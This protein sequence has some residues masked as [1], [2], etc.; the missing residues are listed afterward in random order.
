MWSDHAFKEAVAAVTA[1]PDVPRDEDKLRLYGLY[2]QATV[3]PAPKRYPGSVLNVVEFEKY[4]AWSAVRP[5]SINGAR[6]EY[7]ALVKELQA[8]AQSGAPRFML[9]ERVEY[10]DD[11]TVD[12][13][14][15]TVHSVNPLKVKPDGWDSS[16]TFDEV[17][18][19]DPNAPS[20]RVLVGLVFLFKLLQF[21]DRGITSGSPTEFNAFIERTTGAVEQQAVLFASISSA[22]TVGNLAGCVGA[23]G[24]HRAGYTGHRL[25]R[26]GMTL[27]LVG[28]V[29]SS[30]CSALGSAPLVFY[31]FC[32]ARLLV[33][34]GAGAVVV[35]WPPYIE[36]IAMPTER[37]M[38]MTLVEM[39]T[40]L[41]AAT[42]YLYSA[43]MTRACGWGAAYFGVAFLGAVAIVAPMCVFNEPYPYT[44]ARR[45]GE[46][47]AVRHQQEIH[48]IKDP[49]FLEWLEGLPTLH[50]LLC[51]TSR[52]HKVQRKSMD[53]PIE[54][55][56]NGGN[57]GNGG[58]RGKLETVDTSASLLAQLE[59]MCS[60]PALVF[61][62]LGLAC[63]SGGMQGLQ[64]FFPTIGIDVGIWPS[65]I[66]AAASFGTAIVLG[67]VV[68]S[69][70][71][72][73]LASWMTQF[74]FVTGAPSPHLPASPSSPTCSPH[75]PSS[76]LISPHLP[77]SPPIST[78][79]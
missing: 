16:H 30:W 63:A 33:G 20:T 36:S 11:G 21:V 61:L 69:P 52:A 39:G 37:S 59:T 72:G 51:G 18:S 23:L 71:H 73:V 13:H 56:G 45:P 10:R 76:P 35:S 67:A 14:V 17:R 1:L 62:F 24:L 5:L 31:L 55:A 29:L 19:F 9:N 8:A 22:Y 44:R 46:S 47:V 12:W 64:V 53:V 48:E 7:V 26:T 4:K 77:S 3:G 27:W 68:G 60:S 41:G 34:V 2:K 32:T 74:F 79:S 25:L 75:L 70:M 42:G 49:G 66:V 28:I 40:S 38:A 15:G 78:M 50:E 57:D 6:R 65:E 58:N 54:K 43:T